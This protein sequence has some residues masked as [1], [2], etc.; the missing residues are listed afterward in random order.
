MPATISP[1]EKALEILTYWWVVAAAAI[2][3]GLAGIL[4]FAL[5]Q[6]VYEAQAR[7]TM[8][9]DFTRTGYMEQYDKDLALGSA[10]GVIYSA[11]VIHQVVEAARVEGIATDFD[12]LRKAAIL[13]RKSYEWILRLRDNSP[14]HAAWLANKW[15]EIGVGALDQAYRHSLTAA[16]LQD[17]MDSLSTCLQQVGVTTAV[18]LCPY[19]NVKDLQ[20]ELENA[21]NQY[22]IEKPASRNIFPGLTYSVSLLASPPASPSLYGRNNVTAAGLFIGLLVGIIL[23]TSGLPA[24]IIKGK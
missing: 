20:N 22:A 16:N 13:E 10:A 8:G 14:E 5:K 6:P 18:P 21:E 12:T 24:R 3:G 4:F 15:L 9:I 23:V 1:R 7:V 11:D 2:I 17:Y 19:Q